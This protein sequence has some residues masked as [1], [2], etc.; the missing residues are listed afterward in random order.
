MSA[1][2]D[3]SDFLFQ[4]PKMV[5]TGTLQADGEN[6]WQPTKIILRPQKFEFHLKKSKIISK[7]TFCHVTYVTGT[8]Q[9]I[10]GDHIFCTRKLLLDRRS[11]HHT[12]RNENLLTGG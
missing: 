9:R 8:I 7:V 12:L 5:P 1:F 2:F 10:S 6:Q 4:I 3:G 11:V